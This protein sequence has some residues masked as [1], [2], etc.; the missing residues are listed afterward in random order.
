MVIL[1]IVQ[2]I[3][4]LTTATKLLYQI[5]DAL[6]LVYF[7]QTDGVRMIKLAHDINFFNELKAC[8]FRIHCCQIKSL[9]SKFYF[10]VFVGDF[11]NN[12]GYSKP[13]HRTIVNTGIDLFK[14]MVLSKGMLDLMD[15][16]NIYIPG[17]TDLIYV[18]IIV[19][20]QFRLVTNG[21][22]NVSSAA[23]ISLSETKNASR[24]IPWS[25]TLC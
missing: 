23:L 15:V 3:K 20:E 24:A 5:Y 18:I 12:A 7:F 9:D 4:Q 6:A 1:L 8:F 19:L 14:S 22:C 21:L 25:T 17:S 11:S 16:I 10:G 2:L 13:Q